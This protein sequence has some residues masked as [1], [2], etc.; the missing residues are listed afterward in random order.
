MHYVES[1]E[2]FDTYRKTFA[3][4]ETFKDQNAPLFKGLMFYPRIAAMKYLVRFHFYWTGTDY[5]PT[6][7]GLEV[8]YALEAA[9][10]NGSRIVFMGNE[11]NR[12]TREALIHETRFNAPT[13]FYKRWL[14]RGTPWHW[15]RADYAMKIHENT[16][17]AFAEQIN[18]EY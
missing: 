12:E 17:S 2:E 15:E 16:K 4:L 7:A 11:L 10:R 13:Y 3:N 5:N 8:K 9:E 14:Y 1:Q 18:D 6:S